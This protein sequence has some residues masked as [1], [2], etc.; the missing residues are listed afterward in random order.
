VTSP[1]NAFLQNA[2]TTTPENASF[3]GDFSNLILTRLGLDFG[4]R[5]AE[6]GQ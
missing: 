5:T 4:T 1:Q 2:S 3:F 6:A